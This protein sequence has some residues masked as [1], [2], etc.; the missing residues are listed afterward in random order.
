MRA[1]YRSN[2]RRQRGFTLIE[3]MIVVAIVGIL[4]AIAV[5]AYQDYVTHS[6]VTEGLALAAT[7]KTAVAENAI[8]GQ[9]LDQGY[10]ETMAATR[11]V[12]KNGITIDHETGEIKIQYA[13]NV[14]DGESNLL[15]LKPTSEG[16]ALTGS[17][18]ASTRPSGPIRWDCYAKDVVARDDSVKPANTPTLH[19]KYT[20]T[21]CR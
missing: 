19:A 2:L 13:E 11:S 21:E 9:R 16:V 14:S 20:P 10:P 6:R 7:A 15:V 5:P 8:A 1:R 3:L 4:A 17:D 12:K 18:S